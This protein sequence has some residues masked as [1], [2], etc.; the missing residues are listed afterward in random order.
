VAESSLPARIA[1]A[2]AVFAAGALLHGVAGLPA[3]A[4]EPDVP[5]TAA[6]IVAYHDSGEWER[7]I[8]AVIAEARAHLVERAGDDT[9]RRPALVLDV[10]DT[11]L[12]S[13]ECLKEVRFRRGETGCPQD[14]K[15]PAIPQTL[16]LYDDAHERGVAVFLVTGRRERLRGPTLANLERAGFTG[17]HRLV[18]RPNRERAGTHDGWKARKRRNISRRGF[19]ILANVGDQRS[20]LS[21]GYALRRFK[22]P[23]PM[24]VIEEA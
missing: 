4:D 22:L 13:Y 8:G 6:E 24:Y 19:R 21:G 1:T 3:S 17:P 5:A 12:S 7:D 2:A 18:M 20:D 11:S 10:D 9:E 23:N 16:E 14:G 15:M